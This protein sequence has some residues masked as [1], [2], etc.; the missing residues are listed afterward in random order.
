M[1]KSKSKALFL[2]TI[3]LKQNNFLKNC[4]GKTGH[5]ALIHTVVRAK[6][7]KPRG[8]AVT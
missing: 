1:R 5:G 2:E 6:G 7:P 3:F 8:S 4:V